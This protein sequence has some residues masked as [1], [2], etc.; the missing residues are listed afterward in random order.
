[1]DRRDTL[2][3]LKNIF[4]I[5]QTRNL[6]E[7]CSQAYTD[8]IRVRLEISAVQL[9]FTAIVSR[10]PRNNSAWNKQTNNKLNAEKKTYPRNFIGWQILSWVCHCK[11]KKQTQA[12]PEILNISSRVSL[13]NRLSAA[14][15]QSADNKVSAQA[16]I[17]STALTAPVFFLSFSFFYL[18]QCNTVL[19]SK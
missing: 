4:Y 15:E 7:V 13:W 6:L 14:T 1:M 11:K 9:P 19:T 8:G 10:L 2:Q 3:G 5:L 12:V 16:I 18:F 17:P